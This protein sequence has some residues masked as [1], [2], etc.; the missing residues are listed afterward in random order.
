MI[1]QNRWPRSILDYSKLGI[2]SSKGQGGWLSLISVVVVSSLI[3]HSSPSL[4]G[5]ED[6]GAIFQPHKVEAGS[7][8]DLEQTRSF[9]VEHGSA[10]VPRTET[11]RGDWASILERFMSRPQSAELAANL[12]ELLRRGDLSAAQDMLIDALN[13]GTFAI[14]IN[15][16]I[17]D[18]T[19]QAML[20]TVARKRHDTRVAQGISA[21][22]SGGNGGKAADFA[23][24]AERERVRADMA[25]QELRIVQEQLAASRQQTARLAE[26]EHVLEEEKER[27]ASAAR[28]LDH[29]QKQNIDIK[30][31][32]GKAANEREEHA[33]EMERLNAAHT[34]LS[35]KLTAAHEKIAKLERSSAEAANLQTALEREKRLTTSTM[36]DLESLKG[37]LATLQ[38]DRSKA[39]ALEAT[40]AQERQQADTALQQLNAL[41]SQLAAVQTRNAKM[42]S[43]LKQEGERSA[44]LTRQL[45]AALEQVA[46]LAR[47]VA[48]ENENQ[49]LW[50]Q[51]REKVATAVRELNALRR[52]I[53]ILE[54]YTEFLP[55]AVVF[56]MPFIVPEPQAS[57]SQPTGSPRGMGVNSRDTLQPKNP[58]ETPPSQAR[59]QNKAVGAETPSPKSLIRSAETKA[60]KAFSKVNKPS[61]LSK[62]GS[63]KP[64]TSPRLSV[65]EPHAV[66][67][68]L[69]PILPASILPDDGLW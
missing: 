41:Q 57:D 30:A 65:W 3:V 68:T 35:A 38:R 10:E 7:A 52:H 42:Q 45:D 55:S 18:P 51:E 14:Y 63:A 4:A 49:H 23:A 69:T 36:L 17:Q 54:H 5:E 64:S 9:A 47:Q 61:A 34:D 19:L 8:Q 26:V 39:T 27:V 20:Q 56:Q 22:D 59:S 40:E 53:G 50:Q 37:Q 6:G 11:S 46:N 33:R 24:I 62:M 32:I 43:E 2:Q 48:T 1:S 15:N 28:Q 25:L 13:V 31:Q 12:G 67:R 44:G 60:D 58:K 21:N 29:A 66:P 16:D